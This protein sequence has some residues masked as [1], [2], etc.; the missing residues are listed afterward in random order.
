MEMQQMAGTYNNMNDENQQN[1]QNN[2]GD[3]SQ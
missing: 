1:N 2:K 3:I